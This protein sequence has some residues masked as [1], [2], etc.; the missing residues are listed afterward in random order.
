MC[1]SNWD[2]IRSSS[3]LII[4]VTHIVYDAQFFSFN[5][6][7][8][9]PRRVRKMGRL[10]RSLFLIKMLAVASVMS[11]MAFLSSRCR[12]TKY[13]NLQLMKP[14]K[15]QLAFNNTKFIKSENI[16]VYSLQNQKIVSTDH[17]GLPNETVVR[18]HSQ[19]IHQS[20]AY[21]H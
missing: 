1:S 6:S 19:K 5:L 13:Y 15:T 4:T 18:V 16:P 10:N 21:S 11:Q 14:Q 12:T 17:Y 7:I 2:F 3:L 8:N 9:S 20:L